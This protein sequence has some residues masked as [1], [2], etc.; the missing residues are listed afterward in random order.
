MKDT[1]RISSLT[2]DTYMDARLSMEA[3]T[4]W[5]L[6]NSKQLGEDTIAHIG[7][8]KQMAKGIKFLTY[9]LAMPPPSLASLLCLSRH[10]SSPPPPARHRRSL[11]AATSR[12]LSSPSL[13]YL[14]LSPPIAASLLSRTLPPPPVTVARSPPLP[15]AL[16]RHCHS[17]ISPSLHPSPLSPS[18][19][20]SRRLSLAASLR[21]CPGSGAGQVVDTA[22]RVAVARRPPTSCWPRPPPSPTSI[23]SVP[24]VARR[25]I[26]RRVADLALVADRDKRRRAA[27]RR[28]LGAV[29]DVAQVLTGIVSRLSPASSPPLVASPSSHR[30]SPLSSPSPRYILYK[31]I[32]NLHLYT[33]Y[34]DSLYI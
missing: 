4:R 28:G 29:E 30:L 7:Y 16:S 19:S 26:R 25:K 1:H 27:S 17:P 15:P 10:H 33:L 2:E 12:S 13:P 14:S 24:P 11:T 22:S 18:S 21:R 6:Q 3:T 9:P 5:V 31:Y 32:L 8:P 20:L 34:I 23:G